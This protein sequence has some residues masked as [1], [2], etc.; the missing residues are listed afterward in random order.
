MNGS[1]RN[2][3]RGIP[4]SFSG[5]LVIVLLALL[6]IPGT[7]YAADI[8]TDEWTMR[9]VVLKSKNGG[10][11]IPEYETVLQ[12]ARRL[13]CNW[14]NIHNE[15]AMDCNYYTVA[16]KDIAPTDAE[17]EYIVD[18]AHELGM[19]V[20]WRVCAL[21]REGDE[22][23]GLDG[24]DEIDDPTSFFGAYEDYIWSKPLCVKIWEST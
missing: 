9:S 12:K 2:P 20:M 7:M 18:R 11:T 24:K 10:F 17:L 5:A 8:D 23:N 22:Y 21:V 13:G 3:K 14:I 15:A 4:G 6:L 1:N 19:K 16:D